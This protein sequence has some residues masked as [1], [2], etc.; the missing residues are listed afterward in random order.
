VDAEVERRARDAVDLRVLNE[1]ID[2]HNRYYPIEA[3][4]PMDPKT[5]TLL[6][7]GEPWVPIEE[8]RLDRVLSR[9]RERVR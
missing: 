1:L 3:D 6:D 2:R 7:A 4:L 5:G 9:W 8:V